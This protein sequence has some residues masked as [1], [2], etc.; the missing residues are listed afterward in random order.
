MGRRERRDETKH[1]FRLMAEIDDALT[2]EGKARQKN[3]ISSNCVSPADSSYTHGVHRHPLTWH[4]SFGRIG[5]STVGGCDRRPKHHNEAT[6]AFTGKAI[7][8]RSGTPHDE[9]ATEPS[10]HT[11]SPLSR[12]RPHLVGEEFPVCVRLKLLDE[13]VLAHVGLALQDLHALDRGRRRHAEDLHIRERTKNL[14][15]NLPVPAF[16][17][18]PFYIDDDTVSEILTTR[19]LR[20]YKSPGSLQSTTS[21]ASRA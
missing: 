5:C 2:T 15:I 9:N 8:L 19:F 16:Q 13:V 12:L 11:D 18:T 7:F 20:A 4:A 21:R 1:T 6:K 14:R 3:V 10:V 17:K